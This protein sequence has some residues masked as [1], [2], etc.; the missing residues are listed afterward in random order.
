MLPAMVLQQSY[1]EGL[2]ALL[3]EEKNGPNG[4]MYKEACVLALTRLP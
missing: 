4:R 2:T 1:T 3:K